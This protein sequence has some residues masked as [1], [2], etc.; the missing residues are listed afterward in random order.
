[1]LGFVLGLELLDRPAGAGREPHQCPDRRDDEDRRTDQIPLVHPVDES[2]AGRARE[3]VPRRAAYLAG[4]LERE[5]EGVPGVVGDTAREW[6]PGDGIADLV[7]HADIGP[8]FLAGSTKYPQRVWGSRSGLY[9][10]FTRGVEDDDSYAFDLASDELNPIQYLS[11]NRDLM[12]LTYGGE[13]VV[14]GGIEKPITPTNVRAKT[15]R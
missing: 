5:A 13:W 1:M 6:L 9:L 15:S 7:I 11:S 2:R 10:D 3:R 4:G 14:L 12:V 8:T